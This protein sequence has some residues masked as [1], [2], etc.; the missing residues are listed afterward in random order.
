M[1]PSA[2]SLPEVP[3]SVTTHA[4]LREEVVGDLVKAASL[5]AR[6]RISTTQFTQICSDC[7]FG[8]SGGAS[9][10][11]A[12][13]CRVGNV[14]KLVSALAAIDAGDFDEVD[15]PELLI[16]YYQP[17]PPP[18]VTHEAAAR[19]AVSSSPFLVAKDGE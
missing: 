17:A 10:R 15:S 6:T 14:I 13:T 1:F 7:Q 9:P 4:A 18:P 3:S 8:W 16:H 5:L 11:H 2:E 19:L 12:D